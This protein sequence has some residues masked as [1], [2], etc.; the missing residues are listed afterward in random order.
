MQSSIITAGKCV[1]RKSI[2]I[3]G[4]NVLNEQS[5]DQYIS[6]RFYKDL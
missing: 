5:I 1:Q 6:S 3:K 2:T 4:S